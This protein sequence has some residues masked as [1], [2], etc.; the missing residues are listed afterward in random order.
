MNAP[1]GVKRCSFNEQRMMTQMGNCAGLDLGG[2]PV[3]V[4]QAGRCPPLGC[5]LWCVCVRVAASFRVCV[6][7]RQCSR[8]PPL[9][10]SNLSPNEA[11]RCRGI[12]H[13][14]VMS[15]HWRTQRRA[16]HRTEK[17][18]TDMFENRIYRYAYTYFMKHIYTYIYIY[19]HIYIYI[20]KYIYIYIFIYIYIS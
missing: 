2:P 5:C 11:W 13:D 17:L 12:D 7:C 15:W 19:I 14:L 9:Y 1:H 20:C 16:G 3:C 4:G 10:P 6:T 18:P 8:R